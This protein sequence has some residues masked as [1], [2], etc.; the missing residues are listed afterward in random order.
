MQ[1]RRLGDAGIQLSE[2]G[3]GGWLTFGNAI[4]QQQAQ[5]VMNGAFDGGINF[6][7]SANAYARGKCEESWGQLLQDR[8]RSSYVLA[9]K[10]FF[11]MGDGPN[12]RGLSRKHIMEQCHA[13]LRRLKTDYIDLYQCHR[14]DEQTP[15]EETIRAMD[16]LIRQGKVLYWGFSEWPIEQ[17]EKCLQICGD[18]YDKPKGSQP[19][20]SAVARGAEHLVF[21]LCHHA[22]IGQVVFS[23]L[24]QGV[25]TGKYKPGAALPAG[26]RASDDRQ[27][28]FIKRFTEDADLLEKVQRL[29]VVADEQGCTMSQLAL[30]WVLRRPEVTSCIIG[31]TSPE[32]VAEN[33][34]AS[35]L[36]LD[37][38][39][40]RRIEEILA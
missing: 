13:S 1:Y 6:F 37:L 15:L 26:S 11:P 9:T 31:A 39:T 2:I 32:Q 27:N 40:V 35:G 33:A 30:A 22:G 16:D 19:Q 3:L 5:A 28:Q 8:S 21:P 14:H 17:I 38:A 36:T 23:P 24:A 25:L 34:K 20:Y 4:E 18:R 12:D 7:D 29:H 10:V